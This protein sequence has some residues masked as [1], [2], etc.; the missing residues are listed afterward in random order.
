[1]VRICKV[2]GQFLQKLFWFFSKNFLHFRSDMTEKQGVINL[3]SYG[4][5]SYASVVLCDFKVIFLGKGKMQP[6]IHFSI[7]FHLHTLHNWRSMYSNFLIFYTWGGI[8]LRA[9][10]FLLL[11]FSTA[12]SSSSINS[13][14]LMS[15]WSLIIYSVSLSADSWNVLF[16]NEV[17]LLGWQLSKYFF[18]PLTSFT[19]F[20]AIHDCLSSTEFL[21]LLIW[22]WM[23]STCCFWYVLVLSGF[24]STRLSPL[25]DFV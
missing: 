22:P 23:Y 12:S 13:P 15:S 14:N 6:F 19:I 24:C 11:I 9:A 3:S 17:F 5:K 2:V 10:D 18:L 8:L 1:M 7:L 16:I 21:I 20:H 25:V 4:S